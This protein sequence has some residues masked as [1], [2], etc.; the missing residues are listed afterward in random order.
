LAGLAFAAG[1]IGLLTFTYGLLEI[2]GLPHISWVCASR[3]DIV[4]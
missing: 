4:Y 2:A 1:T 3:Q